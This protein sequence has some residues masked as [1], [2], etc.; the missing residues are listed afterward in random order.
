MRLILSMLAVC[1]LLPAAETPNAAQPERGGLI[2]KLDSDG[3]GRV[4]KAE[5]VAG[6]ERREA[7]LKANKPEVYAKLDR[8][9]DGQVT[10]KDR[11]ELH[12]QWQTR[13]AERHPD[14]KDRLDR[15]DD[16]KVGAGERR[17][18]DRREDVRDRAENRADRRE[19]VR[20]AKHDGGLL[21]ELEDVMDRREDVRDRA[22]DRRD[23]APG[24]VGGPGRK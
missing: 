7:W 13:F 4:S 12:Q 16:G 15:N 2:A 23:R 20:D 10:L 19:D 18:A 24:K 11:Q 9:G 5:W 21:D 1:T 8:D 14:L 6:L 17:A 3:D 22:E